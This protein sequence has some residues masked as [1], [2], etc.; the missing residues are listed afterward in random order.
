MACMT[1]MPSCRRLN[2]DQVQMLWHYRRVREGLDDLGCG[3]WERF[4]KE[5]KN[6]VGGFQAKRHGADKPSRIML[7]ISY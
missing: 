7:L 5:D 2:D 4:Q 6:S 1:E 3:G